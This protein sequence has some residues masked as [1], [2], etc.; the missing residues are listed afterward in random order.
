MNVGPPARRNCRDQAAPRD[1]RPPPSPP[2]GMHA[3]STATH[4]R[5][6]ID[7]SAMIG[8]ADSPLESIRI[9]A[10]IVDQTS[11]QSVVKI[12]EA[13]GKPS[14]EQPAMARCSA[15]SHTRD[16]WLSHSTSHTLSSP[17]QSLRIATPS[18]QRKHTTEQKSGPAAKRRDHFV[19]STRPCATHQARS[20]RH[21]ITPWRPPRPARRL[22]SPRRR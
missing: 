12:P 14:G 13:L 1:A 3:A 11:Q 15:Q 4:R 6:M 20:V 21:G 17:R 2:T 5:R 18:S 7:G 10:Q 9:F 19:H 22:P 8:I 16:R